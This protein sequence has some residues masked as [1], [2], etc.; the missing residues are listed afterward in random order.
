MATTLSDRVTALEISQGGLAETVRELGNDVRQAQHDARQDIEK[1]SSQMQ[2]ELDQI[3]TTLG[4]LSRTNWPIL[5]AAAGLALTIAGGIGTVTSI[6]GSLAY[7]NLSQRII[8]SDAQLTREI[9]MRSENARRAIED[10]QSAL[11]ALATTPRH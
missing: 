1:F 5:F 10:M 11:K 2:M 3:K 8:S 4:G 7:N 6:I 9:E